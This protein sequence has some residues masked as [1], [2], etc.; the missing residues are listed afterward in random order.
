M[1]SGASYSLLLHGAIV[2]LIGNL[3]G[4]PFGRAISRGRPD[5][6]VRAWRVA[7]SGIVG[8]GTTML[9]VGAALALAQ[10]PPLEAW[11]VSASLI[12]SGY[13]FAIALPIGALLGHRGIQAK[14]PLANRLVFAGNT[15]GALGSLIGA[16]ILVW[17]LLRLSFV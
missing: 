7:H 8:G 6:E 17:A 2:L 4:A 10:I 16:L 15:V 11:L 13:G 1:V 12:A 14:G 9:A 3:C 5:D